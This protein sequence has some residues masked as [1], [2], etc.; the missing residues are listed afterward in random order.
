MARNC[1]NISVLLN[2][3]DLILTTLA[4]IGSG[5]AGRSLLYALSREKKQFD[6]ITLVYSDEFTSPCTLSSTAIVAP[7][8]ITSG[9]SALGDLLMEGYKEFYMHFDL[10]HPPGVEAITQYTAA[11]KNLEMFHSRYPQ[12][13]LSKLFFRNETHV[14]TEKAFLINPGT[15]SDWLLEEA[16]MLQGDRL[17]I[18]NDMVV[19]VESGERVHLKTHNGRN[20]TF[21]KVIFTGGSYNRFWKELAPQSVLETSKPVQGSYLEFRD[22]KLEHPSFSLTLNG[23]NLIWSAETRI[24]LIGSTTSDHMHLLPPEM[25]L[26]MIFERLKNALN[27]NLPDYAQSILKVGLREKA[28]KREPYIIKEGNVL[29]FGGLYK[30]GFTLSLKMSKNLSH[31]YL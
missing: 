19:E 21:D 7:R 27:L 30:N 18:L 2:E 31:Q 12:E 14:A 4:I 26:K 25:E 22:V 6:K 8:G 17:D 5:I 29:F 3:K 24:L 9:H 13:K 11:T 10:D 1:E 23:D 28:K 15:Y 16:K 20:I